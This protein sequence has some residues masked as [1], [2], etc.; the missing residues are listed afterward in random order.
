MARPAFAVDTEWKYAYEERDV[1]VLRKE[2]ADS[3]FHCWMGRT[4]IERP[5]GEIAEFLKDPASPLVY[6]KHVTESKH[7]KVLSESET[8][9]D[10]IA[11]YFTEARECLMSAKRD[12]LFYTRFAHTE[13][14]FVVTAFSVDHPEF[15]PVEG[16]SRAQLQPGSGWHLE[17]HMGSSSRTL[18]TYVVHTDLVALPP[19]IANRV[20]RRQ[21]LNL[22]YLKS[23]LMG[24]SQ[25]QQQPLLSPTT[26]LP[27]PLSHSS[28]H[29]HTH[30]Q[31]SRHFEEALPISAFTQR[32][33]GR[34]GRE[35]E[36]SK[37]QSDGQK[38]QN[39]D[40]DRNGQ[41]GGEQQQQ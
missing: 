17:K 5:M 9:K 28:D 4:I 6:D 1:V 31:S 40:A 33:S 2:F 37:N 26:S 8:H 39:S 35:R 25:H 3:P 24:L 36:E 34:R 41:N 30:T 20:L 29:H 11:Y 15:P 18:V 13:N 14:K 32:L 21:P 27:L 19:I 7:L 10:V 23:H 16:V 22:H 38:M 12:L